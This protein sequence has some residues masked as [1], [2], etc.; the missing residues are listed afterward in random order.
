M[1]S[2]QRLRV[3]VFVCCEYSALCITLS[4]PQDALSDII[5]WT[6]HHSGCYRFGGYA[7]WCCQLGDWLCHKSIS[8]CVEWFLLKV[9]VSQSF[10][11]ILIESSPIHNIRCLCQSQQSIRLDQRNRM[12]RK[13][14]PSG[15]SMRHRTR[16]RSIVR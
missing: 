14:L 15:R 13:C 1:S 7:H 6:A 2:L 9:L 4:H 12:R 10:I 8:R 5:R 11:F 3:C 16:N